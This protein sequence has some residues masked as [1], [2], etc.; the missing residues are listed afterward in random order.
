MPLMP[1]FYRRKKAAAII[2]RIIAGF[3]E[4]EFVLARCAGTA[5]AYRRLS[6][7]VNPYQHRMQY[8]NFGVT[9]MFRRRGEKM[10]ID[11]ASRM[12]RG[13]F[14]SLGIEHLLNEALSATRACLLF[15]N[16]FAHCHWAQSKRRGPILYQPRRNFSFSQSSSAE[17]VST[18]HG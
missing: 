12:A 6:K 10:R 14:R 3:G 11:W 13:P 5:L 7:C 16:L 8:E 15:R 4:L 1:A 2:G 17:L 18:R 9:L